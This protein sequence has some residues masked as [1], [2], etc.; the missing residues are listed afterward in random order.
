MFE[1]QKN[2]EKLSSD[3]RLRAI[4][5]SLGEERRG[6]DKIFVLQLVVT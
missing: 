5:E 1:G 4:N 3:V 6:D 2:K